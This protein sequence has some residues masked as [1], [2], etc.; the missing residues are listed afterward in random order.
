M[1]K[2]VFPD[3][4]FFCDIACGRFHQLRKSDCVCG[5]FYFT[6]KKTFASNQCKKDF[7]G[8]FMSLAFFFDQRTV[9]FGKEKFKIRFRNISAR[10]PQ[11]LRRNPQTLRIK[12]LFLFTAFFQKFGKRKHGVHRKF[13]VFFAQFYK[14]GIYFFR[15]SEC[16]IA[17]KENFRLLVDFRFVF[18]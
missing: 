9:I 15:E 12:L 13:R 7:F 5:T 6:V 11:S 14:F 18:A 16:C 1:Q 17:R 8:D 2:I 4:E 10:L 3:F